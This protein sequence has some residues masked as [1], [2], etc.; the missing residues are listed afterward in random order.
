VFV[1]GVLSFFLV[2]STSED[3]GRNGYRV[4]GRFHDATGLVD[5]SRVE[6]AGLSVGQIISRTLE[7]ASRV[8]ITIRIKP[9]VVLYENAVI[10]KKAGSMLGDYSLE[11]DPGTPLV[12]VGG[13]R[14][15][16]RKLRDGDEIK[17][18]REPTEMAQIIDALGTLMPIMKGILGDVHTLTSG[19]LADIAT[20]VDELIAQ[21][22]ALLDDLLDRVDAIAGDVDD[23]TTAEADDVRASIRNVREITDGVRDLVASTRGQLRDTSG[24]TH[25]SLEQLQD[26][27]ASL[28]HTVRNVEEVTS[29]IERGDGTVGRFAT[30]DELGDDLG[31]LSSNVGT[32]V[33]GINRLQTIVSLRGEY[34]VLSGA[35]TGIVAVRLQSRP[36]RFFLV[37]LVE[38]A[39]GARSVTTT[40]TN[41]S[42]TGMS[43][44]TNIVTSQDKLL[45]SFM[46]GKTWKPFTARFGIKESTAGLGA[47]LAGFDDRLTLSLDVFDALTNRYPRVKSTVALAPFGQIFYLIA[48]GTD[49][50]NPQRARPGLPQGFDVF[51]GAQFVFN[52]EDLKTIL[53]AL[54]GAAS[55]AT[56]H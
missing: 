55:G 31:E 6:I 51:A 4:W 10:E 56:S 26:A 7:P 37:E 20:G 42:L 22:S 50:L 53:F 30:D 34:D 17:D 5:K 47:D 49:M 14:R 13:E 21:N 40:A 45:F 25:G 52:D 41:S 28:D 15:P 27:L 23:V 16:M 39:V 3:M 46:V 24:A 11:I 19:S 43:S 44:A 36:D 33:G 38:D 35:G 12:F 8:K 48:G 9:G 18:V 32:L 29:R 54:G 1:V 2:R